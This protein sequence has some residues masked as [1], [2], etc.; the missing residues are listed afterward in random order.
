[1]EPQVLLEEQNGTYGQEGLC[2]D[3]TCAVA[4]VPGLGGPPYN[5]ACFDHL[6]SEFC[7]VLLG[8]AFEVYAEMAAISVLGRSCYALV[9]IVSLKLH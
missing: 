3:L 4:L 1:M 8:T 6:A 2:A 7:N 9:T 5:H